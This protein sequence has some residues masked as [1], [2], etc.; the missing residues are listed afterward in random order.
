MHGCCA[1]TCRHHQIAHPVVWRMY[2][3]CAVATHVHIMYVLDVISR[4]LFNLNVHACTLPHQ[5]TE[6]R[7]PV[8]PLCV[9]SE[10]RCTHR[11]ASFQQC[12]RGGSTDPHK[13]QRQTFPFKHGAATDNGIAGRGMHVRPSH[14]SAG[15]T[16]RTCDG[17]Q[18]THTPRRHR[19]RWHDHPRN[20]R[21]HKSG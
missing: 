9:V 1:H 12:V 6:P 3:P 8:H 20:R 15:R 17:G 11:A 2:V 14:G 5:D 16:R 21:K 4:Y 13:S 19:A 18:L 10:N 7:R